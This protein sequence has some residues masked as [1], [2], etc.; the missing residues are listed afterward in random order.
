MAIDR[1]AVNRKAKHDYF[2]LETFECGIVLTGTEI[3]SV[4]DGRVNLKDS[5]AL[6]RDRELW[7]IGMHISPYEK[8]SYYNH[9]PERDRKLLIHKIELLRLN[10]KIREKGLTLV[11]L[12]I[13]IKNG[14]HAKIELALAKGKA[15]HDKRD[16]IAE[17]DAKRSM[18]RALRRDDRD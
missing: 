16:A 12:S 3:K 14:K 7:L 5:F 10:S 6:I 15:E 18:A 17:R 13:Y 2:I 1:V 11:P 8:G 4:R 9:E